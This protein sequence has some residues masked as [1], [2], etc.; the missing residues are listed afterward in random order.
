[1][2]M[3]N[4]A[5]QA[6]YNKLVQK[7]DVKEL[8]RSHDA[9]KARAD[10]VRVQR[11]KANATKREAE[12]LAAA[13]NVEASKQRELRLGAAQ[14]AAAEHESRVRTEKKLEKERQQVQRLTE[15]LSVLA[16]EK[17]KLDAKYRQ[18][19]KDAGL[20][21]PAGGGGGGG[22]GA[23]TSPAL[24]L[25]KQVIRDSMARG[26][27]KRELA[28]MAALVNANAILRKQGKRQKERITVLREEAKSALRPSPQ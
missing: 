3:E 18:T 10:A 2:T 23:A 19:V 16:L 4:R 26:Q 8:T 14:A 6:R 11:N 20:H 24:S 1:M 7:A 12:K 5:S 22:G 15:K 28:S 21:A 13:A 25:R 27:R 17:R 9:A